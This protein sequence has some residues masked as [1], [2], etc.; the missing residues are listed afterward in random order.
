MQCHLAVLD[1]IDALTPGGDDDAATAGELRK[2]TPFMLVDDDQIG[3]LQCG[4]GQMPR[5]SEIERDES[6]GGLDG[7]GDGLERDLELEEERVTAAERRHRAELRVGAGVDDDQV[8]TLGVDGDRRGP[9]RPDRK[10]TRLNSSHV[11]ISYAVFCLKK[12]TEHI[13]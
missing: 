9:G 4:R 13:R 5:R 1:Q 11:A 6:R 3:P 8:L 7:R 12:K 10:S 2:G